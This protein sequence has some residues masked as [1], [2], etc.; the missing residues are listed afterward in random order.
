MRIRQVITATLA[1]PFVVCVAIGAPR[2]DSPG[3]G[4]AAG[5]QILSIDAP[6]IQDILFVGLRRIAVR[7]VQAQIATK[8]GARLDSARLAEDVRRLGRLGWFAAIRIEEM[9]DDSAKRSR[10]GGDRL[11]LVRLNFYVEERPFLAGVEYGGSRLLSK[12]QIDKLLADRK[13]VAKLGEPENPVTLWQAANAIQAAL[14][15]LGHPDARVNVRRDVSIQGTVRVHFEI[16]DGPHIPVGQVTFVGEPGVHAKTLRRQMERIRPSAFF[17]G[18]RGKNIFTEEGFAEDRER[19]LAHYQNNGYPEARIGAASAS[20]TEVASRKWLPWPRSARELRLNVSVPI[21][22]GP[23]YRVE[24]VKASESLRV[25]ANAVGNKPPAIPAEARPGQPYSARTIETLR[26][27]WQARVQPKA[28]SRSA[29]AASWINVEAV[30]TLD[31]ASHTVRIRVDASDTPPLIVRRL[32]FRGMHRF[33]DR[34]FRRRVPLRE[35]APFDDRELEAGLARLART[36]YFKPVKKEDVR[37]VT[38]DVSHSA[39][40]TIRIEELGQQRASLTGGRGQFGSTVGIIYT[41]FNLFHG[42]E[43]LSS[44]IDGGP[45]SLELAIGFAKEGFLGSRG[46]LALSVFNTLLR[47]RLSGSVKGPFFKQESEG[48][49][50][51]WNYVLT[52]VD[53]LGVSYDLS[54]TKTR[55]SPV[56]PPGL[57]GLDVSDIQTDTSSHAMGLAWTRDQDAERISF[58]NSVSGGW[59]GGSENVVRSKAEFERAWRDPFLDQQNAWAFRT[60]FS[61]VA[62]YSGDL[63]VYA[64]LLPG[65]DFVRGLRDGN[66]GPR[67]VISSASSSGATTYSASPAGANLIGAASIEYRVRLSEAT[68]AAAFFDIGSGTL[69]PNWLGDARPALIDSTNRIAHVSTGIQLQ[70]TVPGLGVPL[71]VYCALNARRLDR[72]LPMPDGSKFHAHDS[73]AALGWGIGP[74]F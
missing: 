20:K 16:V 46:T 23:F 37:V 61:G 31:A 66:L 53:S 42:E 36:T 74:M 56:I 33:P 7:A 70:W 58:A 73:L 63:P 41:L 51:S 60:S 3:I 71:R 50:G 44:R 32:E 65:D 5:S 13:L 17:A 1:V 43:L 68:Q 39:E 69:L 62:S 30:R 35:G 45:E 24:S 2:N 10:E 47:P 4:D 48:I 59:L 29:G 28:A 11:R 25:A 40:V 22:A 49:D 8:V 54:R 18:L 38:D 57:T 64:R 9:E 67:A 72:W 34:Y 21:E 12:K 14:V 15:A 27:A 19:L 52:N 55:Y 26:R 6:I